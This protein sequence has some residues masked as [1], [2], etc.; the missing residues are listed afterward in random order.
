MMEICEEYLKRYRDGFSVDPGSREIKPAI[1]NFY[2]RNP[3]DLI[4]HGFFVLSHV[5]LCNF[6]IGLIY[7]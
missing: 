4:S 1:S 3:L 7:H 2:G 5:M 6:I